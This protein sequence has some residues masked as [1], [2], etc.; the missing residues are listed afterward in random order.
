MGF[1]IDLTD[2]IAEA[3]SIL[4]A[5]RVY[6]EL[7]HNLSSFSG[8]I[9]KEDYANGNFPSADIYRLQHFLGSSKSRWF[10]HLATDVRKLRS[11]M[12]DDVSLER[13]WIDFILVPLSM[14][15]RTSPIKQ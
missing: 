11:A 5:Q 2:P 10:F 8:D 15:N 7:A 4:T 3:R 12:G 6:A 1:Y 14:M 9:S 13:P